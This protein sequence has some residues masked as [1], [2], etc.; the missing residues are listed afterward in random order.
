MAGI[1]LYDGEGNK[2]SEGGGRFMKIT[3]NPS[4]I[5]VLPGYI[6]SCFGL[7]FDVLNETET[8]GTRTTPEL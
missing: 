1:D 2:V 4:D 8:I 5:N 6:N 7:P 3:A